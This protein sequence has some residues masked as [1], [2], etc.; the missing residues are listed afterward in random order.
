MGMVDQLVASRDE[1]FAHC[2]H[3]Q[4][5]DR[6]RRHSSAA[7]HL[8]FV[9]LLLQ[10]SYSPP[11]YFTSSHTSG[12]LPSLQPSRAHFGHTTFCCS[13]DVVL[14]CVLAAHACS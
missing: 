10:P 1:V 4:L 8:R 3:L 11:T 6:S 5:S 7:L 2:S 9:L 12:T 14:S 13:D